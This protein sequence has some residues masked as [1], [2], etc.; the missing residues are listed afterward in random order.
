MNLWMIRLLRKNMA[1]SVMSI[2]TYRSQQTTGNIV[3]QQFINKCQNIAK[4]PLFVK[5]TTVG[6][7]LAPR[8]S[9]IVVHRHGAKGSSITRALSNSLC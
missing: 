3:H 8:G 9:G 2:Y 6:C 1:L 5:N 4:R 7:E